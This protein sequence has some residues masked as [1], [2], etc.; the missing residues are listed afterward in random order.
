[1]KLTVA[2]TPD[3]DDAFMF[4]AMITGKIKTSMEYEQ[5]IKDI[6]TLND[7]AKTGM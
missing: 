2:H 3:P 5:I 6:E 4:Y 7:E 1:M